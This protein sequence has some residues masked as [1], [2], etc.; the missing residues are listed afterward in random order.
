MSRPLIIG[1]SLT[2][3]ISSYL[4]AQHRRLV[5][6]YPTYPVAPALE[7]SSRL[8]KPYTTSEWGRCDAGD[9]WA[10]KVP[11]ELATNLRLQK[12]SHQGGDT[13]KGDTGS[14]DVLQVGDS[15]GTDLGI[16]WARAF[17]DSW[18]L[19]LERYVIRSLAAV[20]MEAFKRKEKV[21]QRNRDNT[22]GEMFEKGDAFVNG[23]FIVEAHDQIPFDLV[24]STSETA[25]R[26]QNQADTKD[27]STSRIVLRWGSVVPP[28]PAQPSSTST[29]SDNVGISI[30]GGYHTLAVLPSSLLFPS[31][32]SA[33]STQLGKLPIAPSNETNPSD[34]KGELY[35]VFASHAVHR[36]LNTASKRQTSLQTTAEPISAGSVD[37]FPDAKNDINGSISTAEY[38][39]DRPLNDRLLVWFHHQYSRLLVDLAMKRVAESLQ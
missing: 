14:D 26:G 31:N 19:R 22:D 39:K 17:M 4:Y 36:K 23:V 32:Y 10:V 15:N 37:S 12:T 21:P 25:E 13:Q 18:P 38:M 7:I 2:V 16:L 30:M 8:D 33:S 1:T 34:E 9:V 28:S 35:F 20:G 6:R 5:L 29:P 24:Q 3:A 11:S 27:A